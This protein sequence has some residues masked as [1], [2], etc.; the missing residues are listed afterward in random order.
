[1]GRL[2]TLLVLSAL[3]VQAQ[4]NTEQV[5]LFDRTSGAKAEEV[6]PVESSAP[7]TATPIA[8]KTEKVKAVKAP[9]AV[10]KAAQPK[11][12]EKIVVKEIKTDLVVTGKSTLNDK[13]EAVVVVPVAKPGQISGVTSTGE[14]V[15]IPVAQSK[16]EVIS[17]NLVA[18]SENT[19]LPANSSEQKLEAEMT[20]A[21]A[22]SVTA[23]AAP[24]ESFLKNTKLYASGILG[25]TAYP[26]LS[27]VDTAFNFTGAVGYKMKFNEKIMLELGWGAARY[28]MNIRNFTYF[29][30]D[31]VFDIT[32]YQTHLAAK[33]EF[34]RIANT[35]LVPSVGGLVAYTYRYYHLTNG[36]T[37]GDNGESNAFDGGVTAA[38]D[39]IFDNKYSVG[40]DVQYLL[41]ASK[42]I[43]A[44]Y[45]NESLGYRGAPII[46][47][48]GRYAIG[49]SAKINF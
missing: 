2:I 18:S 19:V 23:E 8:T 7:T 17:N 39:Y 20:Q 14:I 21:E 1:M 41:N 16:A 42:N 26:T 36:P 6:K 44:S 9:K 37:A 30:Q 31:D 43:K 12:I 38:M 11:V 48:T 4:E 25:L 34:D 28:K 46:E 49:A 40:L 29:N 15:M 33:Y 32:Q 3:S 10:A 5:V 35:K 22:V 27:N 13:G 45:V 24:K 47:T